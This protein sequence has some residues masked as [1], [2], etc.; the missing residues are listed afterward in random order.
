MGLITD[1]VALIIISPATVIAHELDHGAHYD[2]DK[3]AHRLGGTTFDAD[4][5][6]KEEKRVIEGSEQ[7]VARKLKEI[8]AGEVT[9]KNHDGSPTTTDG[10]LSTEPPAT[11]KDKK[12]IKH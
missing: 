10:P 4:Y 7:R 6:N 12:I 2:K 1:Q 5:K 11:G 9:R 8:R 3:I